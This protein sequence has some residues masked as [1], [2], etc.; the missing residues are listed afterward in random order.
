MEP[1][2]DDNSDTHERQRTVRDEQLE[3][4]EHGDE[5]TSLSKELAHHSGDLS[6][7]LGSHAPEP[8]ECRATTALGLT[9]GIHR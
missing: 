8:S 2:R 1:R 3:W 5:H 9:R 6:L 4:C 7:G